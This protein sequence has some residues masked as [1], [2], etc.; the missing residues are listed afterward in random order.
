MAYAETDTTTADDTAELTVPGEL[1]P[2]EGRDKA[3]CVAA[4]AAHDDI[5]IYTLAKDG[6][7]KARL[8]RHIKTDFSKQTL[9]AD[10]KRTL[11]P[12]DALFAQVALDYIW[13]PKSYWKD[14][15]GGGKGLMRLLNGLGHSVERYS[16]GRCCV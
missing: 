13:M 14:R 9:V 11:E 10:I 3:R 4:E 5:A 16:T 2:A 7:D 6:N 15:T 12:P 1:N 8:D